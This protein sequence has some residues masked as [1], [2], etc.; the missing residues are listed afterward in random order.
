[1]RTFVDLMWVLHAGHSS[2]GKWPQTV[3][4]TIRLEGKRCERELG[5][6]VRGTGG[7]CCR[8]QS[9]VGCLN[10]QLPS[11]DTSGEKEV[12][13]PTAVGGKELVTPS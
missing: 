8:Y 1:M 5:A 9:P 11:L 3:L 13:A 12:P 7:S 6:W 4:W 10:P 2:A